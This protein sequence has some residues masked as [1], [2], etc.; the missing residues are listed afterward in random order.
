MCAHRLSRRAEY[1]RARRVGVAEHVHDRVLALA[2]GDEVRA[3]RDVGVRL[4]GGRRGDARGLA[5]VAL[6]ELDDRARERRREEHGPPVRR[7]G[8]EELLQLLPEAHVEHLVRLVEDEGAQRR[9]IERAALQV[10]D[11]PSG[12]PDHDVHALAEGPR[13]APRI[14][15]PHARRH[16]PARLTVEPLELSLHLDRELSRRGHDERTRRS[17]LS[18]R[19]RLAE[20]RLRQREA[21]GDRL[22]RAG[23]R[24]DEQVPATVRGV[25]HRRLD[26]RRLGVAAPIERRQERRVRPDGAKGVHGTR[27]TPAAPG[28][29]RHFS[30]RARGTSLGRALL[31]TQRLCVADAERCR[32]ECGGSRLDAAGGSGIVTRSSWCGGAPGAPPRS[33]SSARS[34]SSPRGSPAREAA[35]RSATLPSLRMLLLP[36]A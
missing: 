6:R 9:E 1:E 17:R 31:R 26:G 19:R 5:R 36:P 3:V 20:E 8:A 34:R 21:E 10:I 27:S 12:G 32:W 23:A 14:H 7:R 35:E 4:A 11:Q 33:R 25:E 30:R 18:E 24:G 29:V 22:A 15:A 16:A 2:R 28:G 13:L